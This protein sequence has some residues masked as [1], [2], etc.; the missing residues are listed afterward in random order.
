MV[1]LTWEAL[2]LYVALA[3]VPQAA[4][5][6]WELVWAWNMWHVSWGGWHGWRLARLL[7]TGWL[8]FFHAGSRTPRAERQVLRS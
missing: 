7:L 8:D 3:A 2:L 6:S 4:A 1:G 5:F